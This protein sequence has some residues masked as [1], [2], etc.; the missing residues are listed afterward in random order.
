MSKN[1]VSTGIQGLDQVLH[2]GFIASRIYVAHG[3][4]GTGKTT[5]GFHF[6]AAGDPKP[7]NNLLITFDQPA[8]HLRSDATTLGM[9][10]DAVTIVDLTPSPQTFSAMETYDIF[11]PAEIEREPITKE[12][13]RALA[14][15]NVQRVFVDGFDHFR[16]LATDPFHYRRLV[17]SFFRFATQHGATVLIGSEAR[18]CIADADGAVHLE[19]GNEGRSIRVLKFRG[20]DFSFGHHAMRLTSRG[21]Q[22]LP[23]A[24]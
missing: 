2:G 17:Q 10:L 4:P 19:S 11:S 18:E 1:R 13:S 16:Q 6:L 24:A 14:Q 23:N 21:I 12:I 7:G 15:E 22:V 9:G 8:E 20:S 3:E 5:L